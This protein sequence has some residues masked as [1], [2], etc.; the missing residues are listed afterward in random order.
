MKVLAV[1]KHNAMDICLGRG[2]GE[3]VC[4]LHIGTPCESVVSFMLR[5]LTPGK[6]LSVAI[7]Q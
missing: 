4:V 3:A 7:G 2:G 6:D 5:L 1:S